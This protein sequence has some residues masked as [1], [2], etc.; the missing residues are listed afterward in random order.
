MLETLGIWLKTTPLSQ[1]V[2]SYP[3]VWPA[4][5]TLHFIGLA[6]LIGAVCVLDLRIL[7]MAKAMPLRPLHSMM[8]WGVAGFIINM[9]TG[10]LFFAGTPYQYIGNTGFY[11]KMLFILL[12]GI[13]VLVFYLSVY[14][15][16]ADL[17]PGEDA[18]RKAKIVAVVSLACW[19]GVICFGRLLPYFGAF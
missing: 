1:F 18:P 7:G 8:R 6:M 2:V 12:A 11:F 5:E 9:T 4:C 14:S 13:N 10:F 17:G 19:F 15:E 16:V 3:W